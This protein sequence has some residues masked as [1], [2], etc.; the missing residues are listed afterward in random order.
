MSVNFGAGLAPTPNN[1]N[2]N[3]APPPQQPVAQ[4]NVPTVGSTA[5]TASPL[6]TPPADDSALDSTDPTL[7]NRKSQLLALKKLR[8]DWV[9]VE[10]AIQEG[11]LKLV[12]H[13][14]N[15]G[16]VPC[17]V[18]EDSGMP[19]DVELP[20]YFFMRLQD[21]ELFDRFTSLFARFNMQVEL[22]RHTIQAGNGILLRR[23]VQSGV[24]GWRAVSLKLGSLIAS[25]L[26]RGD[27]EQ[28]NSLLQLKKES[29]PLQQLD[30]DGIWLS[31][32]P[33]KKNSSS[34]EVVAVLISHLKPSQ[35]ARVCQANMFRRAGEAGDYRLVTALVEWLGDDIDTFS[36]SPFWRD[37]Q[38]KLSPEAL[39]T[40]V[41]GGFP[42]E[43]IS[44]PSPE[45]PN[46]QEFQLV[47]YGP[48]LSTSPFAHMLMTAEGS[49]KKSSTLFTARRLVSP[50]AQFLVG[51]G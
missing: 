8:D 23:L 12:H 30:W 20:K 35:F 19:L 5:A 1:L 17:L 28:L 21:I 4:P 24:E 16:L 51:F 25:V 3:D 33:L 11:D 37:E 38:G 31:S 15:E 34:A 44:L 2:A 41:K 14:L 13:M 7:T 22:Y 29:Y 50:K 26:S 39:A 36:E 10:K 42:K 47:L 9:R 49:C 40:I 48:D 46:A 43:G 45:K 27:E 32:M 18:E 6:T